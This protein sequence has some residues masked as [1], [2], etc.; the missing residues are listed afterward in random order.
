[1]TMFKAQLV[2]TIQANAEGMGQT[3]FL[4]VETTLMNV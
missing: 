4:Q 2:K 1:M 3:E